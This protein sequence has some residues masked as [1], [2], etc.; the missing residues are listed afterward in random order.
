MYPKVM[1]QWIEPN[2]CFGSGVAG[3][4][5]QRRCWRKFDWCCDKK[6]PEVFFTPKKFLNGQ[7]IH[8][9]MQCGAALWTLKMEKSH[10]LRENKARNLVEVALFVSKLKSTFFRK[11]S[12]VPNRVSKWVVMS[13]KRQKIQ[14]P[15]FYMA[16]LSLWKKSWF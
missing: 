5:S 14:L 12:A 2:A 1:V 10:F 8:D 9:D 3:S 13:S 11:L 6:T 16:L 4:V 15:E 7:N